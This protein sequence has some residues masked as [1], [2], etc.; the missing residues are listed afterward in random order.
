M[1]PLDYQQ[2]PAQGCA[3]TSPSRACNCIGP[4]NGDPVCP[5]LMPAHRERERGKQALEFIRKNG[6]LGELLKTGASATKPVSPDARTSAA[7]ALSFFCPGGNGTAA[8]ESPTEGS[9]LPNPHQDGGEKIGEGDGVSVFH[10][11]ERNA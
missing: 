10:C 2:R 6:L 8:L 5:C 1:S 4:Q 3:N 7:G 9:S 11:M